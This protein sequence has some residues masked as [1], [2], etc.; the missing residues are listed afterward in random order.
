[1]KVISWNLLHGQSIEAAGAPQ[2]WISAC[3][4]LGAEVLGLQEVDEN[5]PRSGGAKQVEE[6]AQALGTT[7]WAYARTVIGTPGEKWRHPAEGEGVL[8]A[9]FSEPSYG[10]GL[11]SMIPVS[12]WSRLELGRS[13]IGLPLPVASNKGARFIYVKDE[14]RV[15][16]IAELVNGYTVAVTHLSFVPFVNYFQLR[17]LQRTLKKLP[18]RKLII[19][20]LNLGWNIP[21]R[22]TKWNSLLSKNTY[23]SWKPAIQFDYILAAQ[24]ESTT[25]LIHPAVGVSDHASIGVEIH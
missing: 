14:P 9:E 22:F 7:H 12:R 6:I 2:T 5:Q 25:P 21:G 19:G 11:I 4:T 8:H 18:G 15:A 23:P 3:A 17:K 24:P 16:L 10:I 1:M 13:W 20:D